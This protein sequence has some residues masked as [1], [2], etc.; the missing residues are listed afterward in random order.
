MAKD[1]C[2]R[3]APVGAGSQ[4]PAL[5]VPP[6]CMDR[7]GALGE[8]DPDRKSSVVD[9]D[10]LCPES[11]LL[12]GARNAASL[13]RLGGTGY[14]HSTPNLEHREQFRGSREHFS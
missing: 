2:C 6:V 3:L 11:L 13:F 4:T 7:R 10:F 8:Y 5:T 12:G 1:S 9:R 14:V